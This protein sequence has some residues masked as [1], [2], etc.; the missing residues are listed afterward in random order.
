MLANSL[1]LIFR[2]DV[3]GDQVP[4]T[5][6]SHGQPKPDGATHIFCYPVRVPVELMG[7]L[8]ESEVNRLD[9][10]GSWEG[11]VVLA[12]MLLHR[13]GHNVVG[14][15]VIVGFGVPVCDHHCSL[16]CQLKLIDIE[17]HSTIRSRVLP[18][19]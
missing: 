5:F 10:W 18:Q 6:V 12:P 15:W 11:E 1:A 8:P 4:A 3:K 13:L 7:I 17:W 19:I 16:V 2:K 14:R 9:Q